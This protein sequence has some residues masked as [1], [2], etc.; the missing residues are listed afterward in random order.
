MTQAYQSWLVKGKILIEQAQIA[1]ETGGALL[2]E[3]AR[4]FAQIGD[5]RW[6]SFALHLRFRKRSSTDSPEQLENWAQTAQAG[7][8]QSYDR[9]GEIRLLI[10]W[11]NLAAASQNVHLGLSRLRQAQALAQGLPM[12]AQVLGHLA[13]WQAS[14]GE[15]DRALDSLDLALHQGGE[16]DPELL[17]WILEQL[18]FSLCR[19]FR[20][21]E[22]E[23]FYIKALKQYLDQNHWEGVERVY[24]NLLRLEKTLGV[25]FSRSELGLRVRALLK[26]QGLLSLV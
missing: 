21:K 16:A 13:Y 19:L 6:Q 4:C 25:G 1:P 10:D 23:R 18:S 22:G 2:E 15:Y 5:L 17:G 8:R 12:A 11:A 14:L 20:P 7:Y 3:A 24:Q 9:L 26:R